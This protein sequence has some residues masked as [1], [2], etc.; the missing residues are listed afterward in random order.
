MAVTRQFELGANT[1]IKHRISIL[2]LI[3]DMLTKVS[4]MRV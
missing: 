1:K 4:V 2:I 3:I